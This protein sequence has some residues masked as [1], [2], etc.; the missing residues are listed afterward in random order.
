VNFDFTNPLELGQTLSYVFVQE[1]WSA[2]ERGSAVSANIVQDSS[3]L[4]CTW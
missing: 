1:H 3:L 4:H 2:V